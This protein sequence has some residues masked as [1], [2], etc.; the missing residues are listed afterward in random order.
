MPASPQALSRGTG[1]IKPRS[2]PR[3]HLPA[4]R[5]SRARQHCAESCHSRD[6]N[7]ATRYDPTRSLVCAA[8]KVG[9]GAN[10][11]DKRALGGPRGRAG[12]TPSDVSAAA[13][14]FDQKQ[15]LGRSA[16]G[17]RPLCGIRGIT[18]VSECRTREEQQFL[19]CDEPVP[20]DR[21][22]YHLARPCETASDGAASSSLAGA[23]P[24]PVRMRDHGG[25]RA[26]NVTAG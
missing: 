1:A 23:T 4:C 25:T 13:G 8:S 17:A 19:G 15:K 7:R 26:I 21:S 22:A 2:C 9:C 20:G 16:Q 6:R 12:T 24:A 14:E 3:L 10:P 11:V 18:G 5:R